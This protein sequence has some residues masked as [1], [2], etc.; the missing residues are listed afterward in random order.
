MEIEGHAYY[1]N[2][3]T[4]MYVHVWIVCALYN[5]KYIIIYNRIPSN[6]LSV[7]VDIYIELQPKTYMT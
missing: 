3:S 2:L 7:A 1:L 6:V 5:K 4:F